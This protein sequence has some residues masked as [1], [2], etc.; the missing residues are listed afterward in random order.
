MADILFIKTSSL[1][2][3]IHHMPAVTEAR[4][5]RPG[6]A[7]LMAGGGGFRAAGRLAS[8]GRCGHAGR[9][10]AL[11]QVA[12]CAGDLGE[13]AAQPA[14]HP[15]AQ[16]MTRSSTARACC[17]RARSRGSRAAAATATT[18]PASASLWPR[19]FYDVRHSGRPRSACGRAQPHPDRA[20]AR[21]YAAGRARFRPRARARRRG[22]AAL[23][24]CCCTPPRGADKQ[25]PEDN[26]I[27]LGTRSPLARSRAGAALGHRRPSGCA[28]NALRRA[29]GGARA[30]AR[31]ARQVA[32][33]I[34]RRRPGRRRRYR[35][36]CIWPR[37]FGVPLVAIFAAAG[38][39][40]PGRSATGPLAV[41][42]AEGAPPRS[43]GGDRARSKAMLR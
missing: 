27:A 7:F 31:A 1:G 13:I 3:V 5:A 19:M 42:G 14:R 2:D 4:R 24:P 30:G 26:W 16:P 37:L 28:A 11:A 23:T 36:C 34:A 20:G 40:S 33:L 17:A 25:W 10:A 22:A 21:L 29:A 32:R 12:L 18:P 39:A 15:R 35:A 9:V 6:C 43:I 8:G 41:L 38:R